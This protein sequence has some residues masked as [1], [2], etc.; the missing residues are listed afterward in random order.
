MNLAVNNLKKIEGIKFCESLYKIDLTLNFVTL[1]TLEESMEE[2][3]YLDE[4]KEIYMTG[5]PCTDWDKCTDYIL[6]ML[7]QLRRLDGL[8]VTKSQ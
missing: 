4:L 2:L 8:E 6:G 1:E 3:Q 5:N 7:P